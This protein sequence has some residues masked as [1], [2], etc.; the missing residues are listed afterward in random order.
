MEQPFGRVRELW[1][2]DMG[3][4]PVEPRFVAIHER[5]LHPVVD[6]EVDVPVVEDGPHAEAAQNGDDEEMVEIIEIADD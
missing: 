2:L 3:L 6:N 5:D 1:S 4:G